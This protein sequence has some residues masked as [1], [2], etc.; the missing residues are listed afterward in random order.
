MKVMF[1]GSSRR[2]R[3]DAPPLEEASSESASIVCD[4]R[5]IREEGRDCKGGTKGCGGGGILVSFVVR[6][7]LYI[8]LARF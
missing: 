7:K 4:L 2:V 1:L 6:F 3:I 8:R 5:T